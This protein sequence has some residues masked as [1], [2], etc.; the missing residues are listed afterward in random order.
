MT[1]ALIAIGMLIG[2]GIF[3]AVLGIIVDALSPPRVRGKR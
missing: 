1:S 3:G 2:V